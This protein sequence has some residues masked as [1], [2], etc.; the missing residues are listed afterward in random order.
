[1]CDDVSGSM[2]SK[3]VVHHSNQRG[4]VIHNSHNIQ[5]VDNVAF[6]IFG[7]CYFTEDGIETG[8]VF[9]HNLG[10]VIRTP[11][12]GLPDENDDTPAVFWITNANNHW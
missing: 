5:V 3:N 11:V 6:E 4:F 7:H 1:M 8:N 9:D 2:I 12:N 10:A